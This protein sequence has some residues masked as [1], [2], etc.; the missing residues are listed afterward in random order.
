MG[1]QW[2]SES[3]PFEDITIIITIFISSNGSCKKVKI[4]ITI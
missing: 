1:N 3:K 4:E 2:S